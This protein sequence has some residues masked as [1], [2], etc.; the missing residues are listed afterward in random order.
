MHIL[1]RM[2][3]IWKL[4]FPEFHPPNDISFQNP[5]FL[6]ARDSRAEPCGPFATTAAPLWRGSCRL[7]WGHHTPAATAA[8]L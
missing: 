5:V 4:I 8:R 7:S 3:V 2:K 1:F 6:A